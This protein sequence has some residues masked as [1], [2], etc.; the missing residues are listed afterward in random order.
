MECDSLGLPS[1]PRQDTLQIGSSPVALGSSTLEP[2]IRG[3]I[4]L[5]RGSIRDYVRGLNLTNINGEVDG[6]EGTLQIKSFKATA[7]AGAVTS[8]NILS[9][10]A[11]AAAEMGRA[12]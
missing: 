11:D 10:P 1:R 3:A 6:S 4:T 2:Q 8:F 5:A 12:S 7:A 9:W